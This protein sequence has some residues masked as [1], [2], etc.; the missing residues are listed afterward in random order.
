[1]VYVEPRVSR[2]GVVP[3]WNL[4]MRRLLYLEPEAPACPPAHRQMAIIRAEH[5]IDS[6]RLYDVVRVRN[7]NP[8]SGCSYYVTSTG[9]DGE[10][11]YIDV[12]APADCVGTYKLAHIVADRDGNVSKSE[13][14]TGITGRLWLLD[15]YGGFWCCGHF[16]SFFS[17]I[18]EES[19]GPRNLLVFRDGELLYDLVNYLDPSKF[20][21]GPVFRF[22]IGVDDGEWLYLFV[23][24]DGRQ[25]YTV[26]D[27]S[28]IYCMRDIQNDVGHVNG[29]INSSFTDPY[30]YYTYLMA[31]RN[32]Y[33]KVAIYD[34]DCNLAALRDMPEV[35][36]TV[37]LES[38]FGYYTYFD[39]LTGMPYYAFMLN[40]NTQYV[41]ARI[42]YRGEY[43]EIWCDI[44]DCYYGL[45][46]Q[47]SMY[48]GYAEYFAEMTKYHEK[49]WNYLELESGAIGG[50][51][52]PYTVE[53]NRYF[54]VFSVVDTHA[55]PGYYN[56]PLWKDVV[57]LR[58]RKY[59]R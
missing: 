1:V 20:P 49:L 34:W 45:Y 46:N 39:S 51:V 2:R 40:R 42:P 35:L 12:M 54:D 18:R 10:R 59:V 58:R 8:Y 6:P 4:G 19:G 26:F 24:Y 48:G 32:N 16:Y 11:Y 38:G 30:N 27:G 9:N 36:S 13:Y 57:I 5:S 25:R 7:V 29:G 22:R 43:L 23:S 28:S 50:N 53:I 44:K 41:R 31:L 21:Y 15:A 33:A 3:L 47:Y 56:P 52:S 17:L 14:D 37:Y 55:L